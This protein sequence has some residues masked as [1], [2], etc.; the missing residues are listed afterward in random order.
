MGG[1]GR[2]IHKKKKSLGG[3]T[4]SLCW[5]CIHAV[6]SNEQGTGCS[7]SRSVGKIPVEGSEYKEKIVFPRNNNV[8]RKAVLKII[9]RC[10]KYRQDVRARR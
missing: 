5:T 3:R 4:E 1:L 2:L 8:S 6:P 7:W 9:T 10:P